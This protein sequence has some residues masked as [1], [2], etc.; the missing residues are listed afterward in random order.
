VGAGPLAEWARE[1]GRSLCKPSPSGFG[2]STFS[3]FDNTVKYH[4]IPLALGL[5]KARGR[6]MVSSGLPGPVS[7]ACRASRERQLGEPSV[8]GVQDDLLFGI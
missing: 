8:A 1:R 6:P 2:A 7:I 3:L 5:S 4:L